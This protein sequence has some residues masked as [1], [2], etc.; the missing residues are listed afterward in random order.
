MTIQMAKV[1]GRE[2][3]LRPDPGFLLTQTFSSISL[4]YLYP[5]TNSC[6]LTN[7]TKMKYGMFART[8]QPRQM[9]Y[10]GLS[11]PLYADRPAK[12]NHFHNIVDLT[13]NVQWT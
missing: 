8:L 12:R 5:V 2:V 6:R 11:S 7:L 4:P 3:T 9:P 1:T 13:L 10:C